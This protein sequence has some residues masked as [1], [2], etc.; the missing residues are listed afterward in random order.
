MDAVCVLITLSLLCAELG[1]QWRIYSA[2]N[3]MVCVING[4]SLM[5]VMFNNFSFTLS[6]VRQR[7]SAQYFSPASV[8]AILGA[9]CKK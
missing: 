2:Q 1:C 3:A 5:P 9:F 4:S 6:Y 7:S 8:I